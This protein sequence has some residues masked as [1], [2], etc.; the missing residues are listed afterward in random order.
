[1]GAVVLLIPAISWLI[2]LAMNVLPGDVASSVLGRETNP[3]A[4]AAFREQLHL[5]DP[6]LERYL[7]WFT[8]VARG[9]L[10]TSMSTQEPISTL[11]A[12]RVE[13]TLVL[14]LLA[15]F[16]IAV[17]SL[18]LGIVAGMRPGGAVD[19]FISEVALIGVGVPD[20]VWGILLASV[21]AVTF[22]LLPGV[23]VLR[24][25]ETP[26]N[27]PSVLVLPVTTLVIV[28][29]AAALRMVRAGFVDVMASDYIQMARLSGIPERRIVLFHALRNALAPTV[30][31]L[32]LTLL[33]LV[34]G[35]LVVET[36]FAYPGIGSALVQ[37]VQTRDIT[38][39][40]SLALLIAITYFL[41]NIVADLLGV[42]LVPKLRTAG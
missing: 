30:Q 10:G 16:L 35:V 40:Q 14:A 11:V 4:L 15:F 17:L 24:P 36:V 29:L 2:F 1:L 28:G 7:D 39:V 5:N 38:Y 41:I 18:V 20:F 42:L 37:A 25:G 27:H 34:G 32:A 19:R 8:G 21:F 3:E 13:N 12:S 22:K 6:L 26:L 33:W 9:D 31:V 23:S